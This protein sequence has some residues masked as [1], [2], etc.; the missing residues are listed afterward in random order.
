[1]I[2]VWVNNVMNIDYV[3]CVDFV[4]GNECFFFGEGCIVFG[5][6]RVKF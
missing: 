5:G 3:E 2:Y 4:F 1:M 6:I